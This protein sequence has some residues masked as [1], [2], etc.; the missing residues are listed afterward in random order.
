MVRLRVGVVASG[1][2]T[3]FQSLVD[4]R[5]RG[6]LS[7]DLAILICN[8]PGA[9]VLER[10]KRMARA[11]EILQQLTNPAASQWGISGDAQYAFG[12]TGIPSVPQLAMFRAPNNWR[13]DANG[14]F[15]KDLETDE[16]K[17]AL[18]NTRDL[19]AAGLFFALAIIPLVAILPFIDPGLAK[20]AN[21]AGLIA[22]AKAQGAPVKTAQAAPPPAHR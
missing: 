22:E 15:A 16:F 4:A 11:A 17:A 3:D 20:D 9:P 2:G 1:R 8:V 13:V 7:V 21:C 18:A 14:K 5:D 6:D 10:A 19:W 12:L